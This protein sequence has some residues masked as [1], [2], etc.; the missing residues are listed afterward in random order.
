[1]DIGLLVTQIPLLPEIFV[2]IEFRDIGRANMVFG[3]LYVNADDVAATATLFD[4]LPIDFLASEFVFK[5]RKE[6][7]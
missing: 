3:R 2:E 1:M 5:Y 4:I 6:V 7:L